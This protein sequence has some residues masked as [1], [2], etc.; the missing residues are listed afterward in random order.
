VPPIS[1]GNLA[2]VTATSFCKQLEGCCAGSDPS[3]DLA[4][5]EATLE[6]AFAPT[7]ELIQNGGAVLDGTAARRCIAELE[8]SLASCTLEDSLSCRRALVGTTAAGDA[9]TTS[10]E[11]REPADGE[12]A[13]LSEATCSF[14]KRARLG[15]RCDQTCRE[16]SELRSGFWPVYEATVCNLANLSRVEAS[17]FRNDGLYCSRSTERC[18][19]LL[20][21]GSAC[22]SGQCEMHLHCSDD[23]CRPRGSLGQSCASTQSSAV[24]PPCAD[25]LTCAPD[26]HCTGM[27]GASV[28]PGPN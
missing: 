24:E 4:G 10:E 11:C 21:E 18:E 25:G 7:V 19:R 15:D 1:V 8:G 14:R 5:C 23:T 9:C 20:G 16:E 2:E 12:G 6:D 27:G 26:D 22:T 17:C 28:C 3:F 13:C